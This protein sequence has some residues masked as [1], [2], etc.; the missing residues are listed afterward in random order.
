MKKITDAANSEEIS[1]SVFFATRSLTVQTAIT[2]ANASTEYL[3]TPSSP[4]SLGV[5]PS[6]VE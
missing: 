5:G 4:Q 6:V 2:T 1:E 3:A